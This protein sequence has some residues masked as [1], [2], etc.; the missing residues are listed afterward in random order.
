MEYCV[1]ILTEKEFFFFQKLGPC[2]VF[3]EHF[4][5]IY[6]HLPCLYFV[7]GVSWEREASTGSPY[8]PHLSE[9]YPYNGATAAK[10]RRSETHVDQEA[11]QS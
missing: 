6:V 10:K 9:K 1:T 8:R 3:I 11:C 7:Y 2:V 5:G 4:S